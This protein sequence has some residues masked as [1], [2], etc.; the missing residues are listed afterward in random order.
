MERADFD[1]I[2]RRSARKILKC[3]L[4]PVASY[5]FIYVFI[6]VKGLT[7]ILLLA[8]FLTPTEATLTLILFFSLT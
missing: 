5:W 7:L 4:T 8:L 2:A 3:N 1:S 6:L